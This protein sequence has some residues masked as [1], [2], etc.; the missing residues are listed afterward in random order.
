MRS[1]GR[2]ERLFFAVSSA[3]CYRGT[4]GL[5]SAVNFD[6]LVDGLIFVDFISFGALVRLMVAFFFGGG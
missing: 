6:C 1:E 3:C 2:Q 5:S 4:H